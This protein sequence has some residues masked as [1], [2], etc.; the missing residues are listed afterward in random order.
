M[1]IRYLDH[2]ISYNCGDQLGL[3]IIKQI[4][5]NVP[6]VTEIFFSESEDVDVM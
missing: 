5:N 6:D 3:Q 1:M 2:Q 4:A